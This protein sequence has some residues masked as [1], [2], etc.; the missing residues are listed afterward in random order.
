M[1][2]FESTA[3]TILDIYKSIVKPLFFTGAVLGASS[4]VFDYLSI[5]K[6]QENNNDNNNNDGNVNDGNDNNN[7]DKYKKFYKNLNIIDKS[8]IALYQCCHQALIGGLIGITFPV[9]IPIYI[10]YKF[11]DRR[12]FSI[13][14]VI[15][16][17]LT[18]FIIKK[19]KLI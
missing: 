12:W 9:S 14:K 4:V 19:I 18:V 10:E 2:L 17:G 5:K 7:I 6:T 13:E 15:I 8:V 3:N 16:F 11:S 1:E